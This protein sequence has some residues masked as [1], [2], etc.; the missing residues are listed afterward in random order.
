MKGNDIIRTQNGWSQIKKPNK[1]GSPQYEQW[2]VCSTVFFFEEKKKSPIKEEHLN[3]ND[4]STLRK[5]KKDQSRRNT[6][7]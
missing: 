4:G 5:R 6:S 2:F 7:I 1:G 3:M